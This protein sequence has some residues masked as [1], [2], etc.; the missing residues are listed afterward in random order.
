MASADA[1]K[2][3]LV[4]ASKIPRLDCSMGHKEATA[5]F[6]CRIAATEEMAQAVAAKVKCVASLVAM[7]VVVLRS[8][9][10]PVAGL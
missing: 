3:A 10:W 2:E 8:V 4:E 7:P 5:A 9:W 6:D 1:W